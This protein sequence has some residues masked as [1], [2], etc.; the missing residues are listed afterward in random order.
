MYTTDVVIMEVLAGGRDET[1]VRRNPPAAVSMLVRR[2]RG[3]RRLRAGR[4]AVRPLPAGRRDRPGAHRLPGAG[5]RGP[6][7]TWRCSTPTGT[8]PPSP[9]PELRSSRIAVGPLGRWRRGAVRRGDRPAHGAHALDR[10]RR[11]RAPGHR[12]RPARL[13]HRAGQLH[14]SGLAGGEGQRAVSDA[15]RWREHGRAVHD[16]ATAGRSSTCSPRPTS[17]SS[18]ASRPSWQTA[19]QV[20]SVVSPPSLLKWTQDMVTSGVAADILA[21]TTTREPDP[22]AAACASR[23]R[24]S[25]RCGL[26]PPAS[27]T[28]PTRRGCAS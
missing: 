25:R 27:R 21:R 8:S 1:H 5:R 15:V 12:A 13:R 14:R 28:S 7:P 2:R 24:S 22:A 3:P 26:A 19:R 6:Q 4:V 11:H 18:R 20:E 9:P 16:A 17:P 23:T 10:R